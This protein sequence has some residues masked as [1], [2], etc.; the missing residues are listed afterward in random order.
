MRRLICLQILL[1]ASLTQAPVLAAGPAYD[2][3]IV[4]DVSGSM[5]QTDPKNLRVP[6]LKLLNGLIPSGSRAG[7]KSIRFSPQ[8]S[9][10]IPHH[11]ALIRGW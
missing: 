9:R 10:L 4:I 11:S 5:K 6:A 1:I 2:F 3:R 7:A 8:G